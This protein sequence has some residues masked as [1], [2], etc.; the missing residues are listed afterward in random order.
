MGGSG[1]VDVGGSVNGGVT[2]KESKRMGSKRERER[3]REKRKEGGWSEESE[4]G[5]GKA[6]FEYI[7]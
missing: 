3:E 6:N 4:R 5:E 2:E 1:S 7:S